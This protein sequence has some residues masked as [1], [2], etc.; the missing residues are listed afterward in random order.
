MVNEWINGDPERSWPRAKIAKVFE[1]AEIE[2]PAVAS[3]R[4]DAFGSADGLC[5][6]LRQRD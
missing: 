1:D 6:L 3:N 2:C 4:H 5:Q